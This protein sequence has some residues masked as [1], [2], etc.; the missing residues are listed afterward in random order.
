MWTSFKNYVLD[1][2]WASISY[3]RHNDI[4]G[5]KINWPIYTQKYHNRNKSEREKK[6]WKKKIESNT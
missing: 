2:Y 5:A 3:A 4:Q 6:R 1:K